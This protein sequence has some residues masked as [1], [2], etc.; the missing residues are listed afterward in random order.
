M[1]WIKDKVLSEETTRGM[2]IASG[3]SI[4]SEIASKAG[5][6]WLLLDMEHGLG[7]EPETL[8][9]IQSL[10]DDGAAPIVRVPTCE[11]HLIKRVLDFG[12]S[13]IMVPM[14]NTASE[15]R[16]FVKALRYPPEGVR[17]MSSSC[18]AAAYG[19]EFPQ[20]HVDAN[21]KILGIVQIETQEG[22]NNV[23]EIASIDGVDIL[24]IGHSDLS[25]NLGCFKEYDSPLIIEAEKKVMR[26]CKQHGKK[27]GMIL[28][29]K[30]LLNKYKEIGF[31]FFSMGTDIGILTKSF[32]EIIS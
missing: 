30:N 19:F 4:V 17:G 13:G 23:S 2:W 24:F 29:D 9:Q 31:S 3:S 21:R 32:K 20:Y 27:M 16:K 6:D 1:N 25:L 8:R 14:I 12:A 5:F 10:N 18:R 28:R 11:T 7:S 26:A 22:L 15:A